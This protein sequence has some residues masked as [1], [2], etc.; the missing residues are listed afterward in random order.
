MEFFNPDGRP[1]V[2]CGNGL[3]CCA[4][5]LVV[6]G[7]AQAKMEIEIGEEIL[8]AEVL[9]DNQVMVHLGPYTVGSVPTTCEERVF[10]T[11]TVGVPHAVT[12][13]SSVDLPEFAQFSPKV[14]SSPLW[15]DE[16]ANVSVAEFLNPTTLRLR[17][18]ERGVEGETLAC[19][20]A[21]AAAALIAH[22]HHGS[23]TAVTVIPSSGESLQIAI[24][25]GHIQLHGRVTPVFTGIMEDLTS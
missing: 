8:S 20:T 5:F 16:G 1:A 15:G 12:F 4:H 13:V 14:R 9:H 10:Y 2:L 21:A 18:Y 7:R 6:L 22:H 25:P 3:R 11:A 23:S 17:T 24:H 19:G